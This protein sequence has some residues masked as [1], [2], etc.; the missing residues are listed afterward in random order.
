[1]ERLHE[2]SDWIV[3]TSANGPS[4]ATDN[5]QQQQ[6]NGIDDDESFNKW[7]KTIRGFFFS[8]KFKKRKELFKCETISF[9]L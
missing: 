8:M 6:A 9:R 7:N 2:V 3:P 4:R 5:K 1:M